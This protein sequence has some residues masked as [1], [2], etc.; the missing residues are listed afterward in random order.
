MGGQGSCRSGRPFLHLDAMMMMLA[1]ID[2][3]QSKPHTLLL[4]V[5]SMD[6]PPP[7][8]TPRMRR[9][10]RL[11]REGQEDNVHGTGG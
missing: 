3:G 11:T 1:M 4:H 5:F 9:T 7:P 6:P 2:D 8:A 10:L